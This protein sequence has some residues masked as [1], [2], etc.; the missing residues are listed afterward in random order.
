MAAG[1]SP[2]I[3]IPLAS[4]IAE[5]VGDLKGAKS[6][7]ASE[8]KD[9][10]LQ[11]KEA[12]AAGDDALVTETTQRIDVLAER[13]K[14]IVDKVAIEKASDE[15]V[16]NSVSN[17]LQNIGAQ[18]RRL[19]G[20]QVSLSD[21]RGGAQFIGGRLVEEGIE[22]G[23]VLGSLAIEGGS[24]IARGGEAV[25]KFGATIGGPIAIAAAVVTAAYL[26][27]ED[28]NKSMI[29][30]ST[31]KATTSEAISRGIGGDLF[32]EGYSAERLEQIT[33]RMKSAGED[34]KR[35]SIDASLLEFTKSIFGIGTP[36]AEARGQAEQLRQFNVEAIISSLG[37]NAENVTV[38]GILDDPEFRQRFG[39]YDFYD[40]LGSRGGLNLYEQVRNRI[41]GGGF[42]I[43]RLR[44]LAA[45][46]QEGI[47]KGLIAKREAVIRI[48]K[49]NPTTAFNDQNVLAH[50]R[51]VE[52]QD[53]Q[54]ALD[55]NSS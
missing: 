16:K 36:E 53:N 47:L 6:A 13:K 33:A 4:A 50:L 3:N 20:G 1:N 7:L 41:S 48:R 12:K 45:E 35:K 17:E 49:E 37:G 19:L 8:I 51:A 43:D 15:A 39:R 11:V 10:K 25:A 5:A 29:N 26:A 27:V 24:A 31:A 32:G 42:A 22:R 34:V 9:L 30:A 55:W 38:E 54:T 23:G 40:P 2:Q 21:I 14:E 28:Q 52:M 44:T 46:R 18:A